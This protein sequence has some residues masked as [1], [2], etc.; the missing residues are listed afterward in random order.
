MIK[1]NTATK[2]AMAKAILMILRMKPEMDESLGNPVPP[3]L[4][5][6]NCAPATK[7]RATTSM[8]TAKVIMCPFLKLA[9]LF[10][11]IY[12]FLFFL[13]AV[14]L[15]EGGLFSL[16]CKGRPLDFAL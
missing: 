16:F 11:Y 14:A 8:I 9:N 12:S 6:V 3:A 2:P 10:I 13:S 7:G 5:G 15:C 4:G 1:N